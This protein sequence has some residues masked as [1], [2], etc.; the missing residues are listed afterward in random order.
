M[1]LTSLTIKNVKSFKEEVKFQFDDQFN[2]LIGPNGGG[3]SNLLDIITVCI[4]YFFLKGYREEDDMRISSYN[5]IDINKQLDK[6]IGDNTESLININFK[7]SKEDLE[8]LKTLKT[9]KDKLETI[10]EKYTYTPYQYDKSNNKHFFDELNP[11]NFHLN[12]ELNFEIKVTTPTF[13]YTRAF[14]S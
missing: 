14:L 10:L 2:I 3:K 7:V 5:P 8:N 1:K 13:W 12:Q 6:Y 9:N 4:R 11:A